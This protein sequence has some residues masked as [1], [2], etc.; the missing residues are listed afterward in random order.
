MKNAF[1]VQDAAFL[2][3]ET[4]SNTGDSFLTSRTVSDAEDGGFW[5]PEA[6]EGHSWDAKG[7]THT[8]LGRQP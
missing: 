2:D 1:G 3:P 8:S 6:E 4:V 7:V 5:T